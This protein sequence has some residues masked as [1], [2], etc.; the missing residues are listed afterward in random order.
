MF[1]NDKNDIDTV[2][3]R[4]EK[5]YKFFDKQEASLILDSFIRVCK[6]EILKGNDVR[7]NRIGTFTN[8]RR[9]P[10]KSKTI[11]KK[12]RIIPEM[13]VLKFNSASTFRKF[14]NGD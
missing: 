12:E 3:S 5:K 2:L 4:L 14:I 13:N 8:Y 6:S 10:R 7:I 1:Q 11:Y 9:A